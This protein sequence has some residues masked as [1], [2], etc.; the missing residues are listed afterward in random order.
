MSD[1]VPNVLLAG[2]SIS[3]GYGPRVGRMLN[4]TFNIENL[5]ENGG[6]SA[7]LL[8]HL[9]EWMIRTNFDL[10]HLN[11]GL[12]DLAIYKGAETNTIQLEQ[13]KKNV[14]TII[15]RIRSETSTLLIWAT[16][17]PVIYER[18]HMNT[19]FDRMEDDVR[20]YNKVADRIMSKYR[21]PVNDLYKT[22]EEAGRE[23]YLAVDGV[24][25]SD[26]G[27]DILAKAVVECL[28]KIGK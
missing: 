11:C 22:V 10:I 2:D 3:F 7:N 8:A 20:L 5:P 19:G 16:T 24:H 23:K 28:L 15:R 21:V 1:K 27:Y 4:S 26:S 12:H 13:Y 18:H 6:T 25:F 14:E 17:T 9:E